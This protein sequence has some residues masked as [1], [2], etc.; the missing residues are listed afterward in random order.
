MVSYNFYL[1]I[2]TIYKINIAN[3]D[4]NIISQISNYKINIILYI[5]VFYVIL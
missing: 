3:P 1:I 2:L 5:I 4:N